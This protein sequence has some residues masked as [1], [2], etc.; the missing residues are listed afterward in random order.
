MDDDVYF[1]KIDDA[2]ATAEAG[3]RSAVAEAH[4]EA[5]NTKEANAYIAI[6]GGKIVAVYY[7]V[8][9]LDDGVSFKEN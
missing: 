8:D 5:Q 1:V 2:A 9:K 6:D 3:K 7:D 4:S